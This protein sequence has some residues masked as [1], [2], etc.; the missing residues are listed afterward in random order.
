MNSST[1]VTGEDTRIKPL[2]VRKTPRKNCPFYGF[3]MAR[4][5]GF[6]DSNGNQCAPTGEYRPCMMEVDGEEPNWEICSYVNNEEFRGK[7]EEYA[8]T[9]QVFPEEFHPKD[10]A[11]WRGISLRGWMEYIAGVRN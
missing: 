1:K 8:N 7:L 3:H 11:S 9:I 5:M 10:Q 4:G 2:V 6:L